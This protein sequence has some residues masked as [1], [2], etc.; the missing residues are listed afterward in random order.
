MVMGNQYERRALMIPAMTSPMEDG[1]QA[2]IAGIR[3]LL[4]VGA[5]RVGVH[6]YNTGDDLER[7]LDARVYSSWRV[8]REWGW[9]GC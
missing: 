2:E 7:L 5:V 8:C 6:V 1:R 4:R 3:A 9:R